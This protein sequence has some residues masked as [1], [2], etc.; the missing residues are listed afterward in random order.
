MAAKL[1][2]LAAAN[3]MVVSDRVFDLYEHASRLRQRT[4]IWSLR[5]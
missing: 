4:L 3:E 2:S 1:T 5:L